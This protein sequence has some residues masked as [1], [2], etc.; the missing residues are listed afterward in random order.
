MKEID[1]TKYAL[2]LLVGVAPLLSAALG[3]LFI[4][5]LTNPV[6]VLLR[7][8]RRLQAG[9]LNHRVAK[10]HDEF[11][12]LA[13]AFNEMSASLKEQM[14]KMQRTEQLAVV[15]ELAAGLAHEIS[16]TLSPA[17]RW[18]CMFWP[19]RAICPRRIGKSSARSVTR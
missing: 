4:T 14:H 7:S 16:R 9:D 15:G 13:D 19:R 1:D 11:G 8:T 3:Y 5:G 12:E 17:S 18:P 10:L 2:Y 6:K